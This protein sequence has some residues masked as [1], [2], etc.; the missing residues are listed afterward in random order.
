MNAAGCLPVRAG[1]PTPG[2][3]PPVG[4]TEAAAEPVPPTAGRRRCGAI[5]MAR[6]LRRF[7]VD[8]SADDLWPRMASR[9]PFGMLATRCHRP[10]ETA[11]RFGLPA[12]TLQAQPLAAW[13]ALH[14]CQFWGLAA[15]I[16]HQTPWARHEG[17]FSVLA[18]IGPRQIRL[19][20]P[21]RGG[22][23]VWPRD[24]FMDLW[25]PNAEAGG[26][27][28]VV[29]AG[30]SIREE[31]IECP[32]CHTRVPLS[33][34]AIF[35]PELW[36]PSGL[37]RRFFCHGCDAGFSPRH[38]ATPALRPTLRPTAGVPSESPCGPGHGDSR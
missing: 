3:G 18:A 1:E 26:L 30:P 34:A 21:T 24:Q 16:N 7:G 38:P 9:D 17:H 5:V 13:D 4:L 14:A 32:R 25:R 6:V 35:R 33:P 10:A 27:T 20:D 2:G 12:V 8:A 22:H 19:D 11:H 37:W 23:F 36:G 31:A 29:V 28:L 15:V